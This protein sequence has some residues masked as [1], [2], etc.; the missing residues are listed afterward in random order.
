MGSQD[1]AQATSGLR[2]LALS[3][4]GLPRR[5]ATQRERRTWP[6][7]TSAN[8]GAVFLFFWFFGFFCGLRVRLGVR[9]PRSQR[10]HST[11]RLLF[12]ALR[13]RRFRRSRS[14]RSLQLLS[15][16]PTLTKKKKMP[17]QTSPPSSEL[18]ES[19][20][21]KTDLGALQTRLFTGAPVLTLILCAPWASTL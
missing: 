5:R 2:E 11:F 8:W 12:L 6:W 19:K 13:V 15:L 7:H 1:C 14:A 16:F 3:L 4:A 10:E 20:A 9:S 17:Y 21:L 18:C